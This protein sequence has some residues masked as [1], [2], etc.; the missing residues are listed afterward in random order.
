MERIAYIVIGAAV[1]V[2]MMTLLPRGMWPERSGI[3][4]RMVMSDVDLDMMATMHQ[5]TPREVSADVL[6]P[7][8]NHL[9]F[10]DMMDGYNIQI[11]T[12]N[13]TFTPANINRAPVDNEG[14]AHIYVNG[15][16]IARVYGNWYHLSGALLQPGE[17]D[18]RVT[19]NAN[20]HGEWTVDGIPV[21]SVVRVRTP[22]VIQ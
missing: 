3:D 15:I 14:H 21:S 12:N 13:F 18:I 16:K 20:D 9:M 10:P 17:N 22:E 6:S 11:L 2:V 5:H 8:V 19:L 1:A 4:V 7:S